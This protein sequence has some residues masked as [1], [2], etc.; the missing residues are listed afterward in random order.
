MNLK[1]SQQELELVND[2]GM[3]ERPVNKGTFEALVYMPNLI[4]RSLMIKD[5]EDT[6]NKEIQKALKTNLFRML[7]A[8]NPFESVSVEDQR[9]IYTE[10]KIIVSEDSKN[11]QIYL[12]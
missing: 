2:K 11:F 1:I 3:I 7:L 8:F 4:C 6:K 12:K 9:T 5:F 10:V